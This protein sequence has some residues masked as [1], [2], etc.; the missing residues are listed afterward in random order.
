MTLA[1]PVHP[2]KSLPSDGDPLDRRVLRCAPPSQLSVRSALPRAPHFLGCLSAGCLQGLGH[3]PPRGTRGLGLPTA[4]LGALPGSQ[5]KGLPVGL[6]LQEGPALVMPRG[7]WTGPGPAGG[8]S[9]KGTGLE[10][11]CGGRR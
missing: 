7:G 9:S 4:A 10:W 11:W 3:V 2:R 6:V 1:G 5:S 8:S